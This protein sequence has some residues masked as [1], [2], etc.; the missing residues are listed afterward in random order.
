MFSRLAWKL[1]RARAMSL[2]EIAY[3]ASRSVRALLERAGFGLARPGM[4]SGD[5]GKPW[6]DGVCRLFD[7]AA[8]RKAAERILA[9]R[10]D[11][12]ALRDADLGFPPSWNRDPK[13]GIAAPLAFG[14][15][16]DY[17]DERVVGDIKY[18]WEPGRHL[19]LVTLAQAWHLAGDAR[20]AE[21]CRTLLD[22][23]FAQCPYPL[24]AHWTS[25][26][27]HGIRLVNWSF[28][29]HLLGGDASPLFLGDGGGA[30]RGRWL[31][32]IFQHCHFIAGHFSRHSS[33]NNHLLGEYLGLLTGALTWPLWPES[34]RWRET[35]RAGFE[36]EALRQNGADGVN[37]EQAFYYQHQVMDMMLIA[38]LIC[39]ANGAGLGAEY[40]ERLERMMEFVAAIMDCAGNVPLVGDA[41][42]GLIVRLGQET[43][44]SPYRSL[45]A[46]GAL[47]FD[48][49]DLKARA[50]R[51]DDKTR[52]LFGARCDARWEAIAGTAH[53]THATQPG[54]RREF[55]E[56]VEFAEGGYRILGDKFGTPDEVRIVADAG[57]LGYLSIAAHGH[58][59][60]LSFTLSLGGE[61]VLIDPGTY[62][63]HTQPLW[64]NYFRGTS[65]HNTVRVD[66]M[67]QSVIG[68]NFL[69]L[70]KAGATCLHWASDAG[71]DVFAG[72]HDGYERLPD[73]LT[74]LREIRLDKRSRR[75]CITDRLECAGRHEVEL[76]WH[77][78]P[79]CQV[80][81]NGDAATVIIHP[82]CH[83][84]GQKKCIAMTFSGTKCERALYSGDD[85][86]P[87]G[88]Y[89][90]RFD[91][92]RACTTLRCVAPIGG[93]SE[94]VAQI[95]Y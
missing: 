64:R 49:A 59:D 29:W 28:A 14:K 18:L 52:W 78:A 19:E 74:H 69:W 5:C 84:S 83:R 61:P 79:G 72:S 71:E 21:G 65:A 39:R 48:R 90:D 81:L 31:R 11:V 47:L 55:V 58:A 91:E 3:R 86:L 40:W 87:L 13:T 68:G 75:V 41:D 16:L 53:A 94:F 51:L 76:F 93:T 60:A 24:G 67:D 26:L 37:R 32:C 30:F 80:S 54:P 66:G 6:C 57:P 73:K 4:P 2:P 22:S 56:F 7:A 8:Y 23:W 43:G 50:G 25:S 44:G 63:Y 10:F 62:A 46:A 9:G 33:A 15:T 36:R 27:E 35:A 85:E 34:R 45:L 42:D 38:G 89:S 70:D 77:F 17:R 1:R 20:F 12:F 88:W 82:I 92:K 95:H